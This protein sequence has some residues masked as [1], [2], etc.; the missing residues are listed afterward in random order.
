MAGAEDARTNKSRPTSSSSHLGDR[1]LLLSALL[2]QPGAGSEKTTLFLG[3]PAPV[4]G[5]PKKRVKYPKISTSQPQ[6]A[7]CSEGKPPQ[8]GRPPAL[9]GKIPQAGLRL[10]NA[11]AGSVPSGVKPLPHL[12][13]GRHPRR[14]LETTVDPEKGLISI[15]RSKGAVDLGGAGQ[16]FFSL[17]ESHFSGRPSEMAL[18]Q[19][20]SSEKKTLTPM[21]RPPPKPLPSKWQDPSA[22]RR[23]EPL[24]ALTIK[25]LGP[26]KIGPPPCYWG[27][28]PMVS[29]SVATPTPPHSRPNPRPWENLSNLSQGP[30]I[31]GQPLRRP[32]DLP[33]ATPRR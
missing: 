20:A 9:L 4:A 19:I 16:G 10:G 30:W 29:S 14:L 8:E 15:P 21:G 24:P 27:R 11:R 25:A 18:P 28:P 26:P 33:A 5:S 7:S 17:G 6:A 22:R 13:E 31:Q 23:V 1:K 3:D 2:Q 32:A 12:G